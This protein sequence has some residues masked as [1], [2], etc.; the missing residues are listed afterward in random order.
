MQGK[1]LSYVY[2]PLIYE[3]IRANRE[4][5]TGLQN[6]KQSAA[7]T[8]LW[9]VTYIFLNTYVSIECPDYVCLYVC[10]YKNAMKILAV[11]LKKDKLNILNILSF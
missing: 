10:V 2:N 3:M 5:N 8:S 6:W 1:F 9:T 7:N 11:K 4:L